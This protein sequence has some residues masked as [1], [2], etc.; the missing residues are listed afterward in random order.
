MPHTL[1]ANL[2]V[3]LVFDGKARSVSNNSCWSTH[4]Y[5]E[6]ASRYLAVL[7]KIRWKWQ[8]QRHRLAYSKCL[9]IAK[10]SMFH[11]S[12]ATVYNDSGLY[13]SPT[14]N[15]KYRIAF[16]G[17]LNLNSHWL[18]PYSIPSSFFQAVERPIFPQT[19]RHITFSQLLRHRPE[20]PWRWKQY[21]SRNIVTHLQQGNRQKPRQQVQP[22]H[23]TQH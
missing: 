21:V 4:L 22:D 16:S 7:G 14:D 20:P 12:T 18:Q 11:I 2:V 13:S 8:K 17:R 15:Y 19:N 23:K 9:W 1:H 3:L 6:H 10:V 5:M